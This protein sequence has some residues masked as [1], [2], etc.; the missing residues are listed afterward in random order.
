V[1]HDVAFVEAKFALIDEGRIS[2]EVFRIRIKD[3]LAE[4][5]WERG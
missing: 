5:L 3:T 4:L 1:V 2:H